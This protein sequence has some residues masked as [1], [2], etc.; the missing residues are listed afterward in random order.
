MNPITNIKNRI[1]EGLANNTA[2]AVLSLLIAVI[3]WFMISISLNPSEPKTLEKIPL[4]L[5]TAGTSVEENG[6]SAYECDVQEVNIKIRGSKTQIRNLNKDTL[7]AYVDFNNVETPGQRALPIKVKST[8]GI[9][10]ELESVTPSSATVSIDKFSSREIAVTPKLTNVTFA[11]GKVPDDYI[12][13]PSTITVQ[14]PSKL[15]DKIETCYVYSDTEFHDKDSSFNVH[16]DTVQ[17]YS[18]D[19][20]ELDQSQIICSPLSFEITVPVLTQ[21]TVKPIVQI[22]NAPDN[23]D[24]NTLKLKMS[25]DT[26]VIASNNANAEISDTYEVQKISLSDFDLGYSKEFDISE[27]LSEAGMINLSG[28]DSVTVSLDDTGLTRKEI[29]LGSDNI[30]I[31]NVPSDNYDYNVLTQKLT[32]TVVGPAEIIDVMTPADF[33]ADASLLNMDS[34]IQTLS[35]DAMISCTSSDKVWSV[36]KAKISIQKVAKTD[37]RSSE[38]QRSLQ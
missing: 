22:I 13:E 2:L 23:F 31:S 25:P 36:T 28:A 34:S 33:V 1:E 15:L 16:A 19:G 4:S 6:L 24:K 7:V 32:I 11:E 9:D 37:N 20:V 12:C 35:F 21:K 18:A 10:F 30:H 38:D 8:S 14:G 3:V 29:T 26:L 5:D 17:L 27:R